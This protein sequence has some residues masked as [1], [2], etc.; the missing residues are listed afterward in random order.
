M[1]REA[2]VVVVAEEVMA[3]LTMMIPM[4]AAMAIQEGL[5]EALEEASPAEAVEVAAAV[6]T[7]EKLLSSL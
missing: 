2:D 3:T 4:K 6:V 1:D 7:V 5:P